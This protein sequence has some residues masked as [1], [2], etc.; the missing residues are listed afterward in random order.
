M[1]VFL[2]GTFATIAL[3]SFMLVYFQQGAFETVYQLEKFQQ[4]F[5]TLI[6][7]KRFKFNVSKLFRYVV[8]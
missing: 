1:M 7:M 2:Q 3:A 8:T 5:Q 4:K 6:N